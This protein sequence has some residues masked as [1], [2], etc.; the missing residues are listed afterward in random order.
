MRLEEDGRGVREEKLE[1][2]TAGAWTA[3]GDDWNDTNDNLAQERGIG[4]S[5]PRI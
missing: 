2:K 1:V 3:Q 4:L 5:F